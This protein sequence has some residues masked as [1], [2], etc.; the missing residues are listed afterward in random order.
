LVFNVESAF[1][2]V[3]LVMTTWFRRRQ[4]GARGTAKRRATSQLTVA[5]GKI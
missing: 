3:W 2:V 1:Q 5:R 4:I